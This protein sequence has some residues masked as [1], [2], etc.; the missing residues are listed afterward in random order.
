MATIDSSEGKPGPQ[1]ASHPRVTG[2]F[3]SGL[4]GAESLAVDQLN[5]DVYVAERDNNRVLRFTENG[6]PH[7]FA[8]GPDAGTNELAGQSLGFG[9]EGEIAVDNSSS[10]L[11]GALYVTTN[12]STVNVF[13]RS[14][15]ELGELTGFGEACG[16]AVDESSGAVYVGDYPSTV[17]RLQPTSGTTPIT[18]ADYE[19]TGLTTEGVSP[20]PVGADSAGHAFALGYFGGALIEYEES[21]F[22]AGNPLVPGTEVNSSTNRIYTDP[23]NGD[24]YINRGD[25]I[26][27]TDS[28][29]NLIGQFGSGEISASQGVAVNATSKHVYVSTGSEVI[30]YGFKPGAY[31]PIDNPAIMHAVDQA[32]IHHYGDFQVTPSGRYA[33]FVSA[34]PLD[35]GFLNESH[36][37]VY[38]YAVDDEALECA[39]CTPTNAPATGDA[40]LASHGLSLTD[41][42]RVF[43]DSTDSLVLRDGDERKDVYEWE[44]LGAG[45]CNPENPNLFSTG[46]CVALISSGTSQFDSSLL[47]VSGDGIDA[48]FFTHDSLAHE[49]ENGPVTKLYDARENGGFFDVPPP[50]L[51]AASD[52]CHGPGTK[53]ADLPPIRTIAGEPG[54]PSVRCRK[55]I[56]K[57]HGKCVKKKAGAED[58]K[59]GK[60]AKK[61]KGG[62]R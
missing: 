62:G 27:W 33:V 4:S 44:V 26:E 28:A 32:G 45:S 30:E 51:C 40:S 50:A 47:S 39:S 8:E 21:D 56:V 16:V 9:G 25:R 2:S 60:R 35:S 29:G 46:H 31:H 3:L 7:D 1:P 24:R 53:A 19:V 13:S 55:G 18:N 36:V 10:P 20:C 42:G 49:D 15:A 34:Q 57:K 23:E 61:S 5:G 48:Y 11:S 58:N 6:A 41:D 12:G 54:K 22:E 17:W 43:F 14:G 52:E 38:R 59:Q 37:E